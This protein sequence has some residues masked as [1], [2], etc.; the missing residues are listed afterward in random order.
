MLCHKLPIGK[1]SIHDIQVLWYFATTMFGVI[2][3]W[4]MG[5][6]GTLLLISEAHNASYLEVY[7]KI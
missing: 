6:L 5:V 7:A 1:S 4:H 2:L 3:M